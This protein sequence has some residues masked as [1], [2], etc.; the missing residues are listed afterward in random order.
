MTILWIVKWHSARNFLW[1]SSLL[2]F[3]LQ[4]RPLAVC[5]WHLTDPASATP[6]I[7]GFLPRASLLP[8][9]E[10]HCDPCKEMEVKR[11]SLSIDQNDKNQWLNSPLFCLWEWKFYTTFLTLSSKIEPQLF[12]MLDQLNNKPILSPPPRFEHFRDP[13]RHLGIMV[14]IRY[15]AVEGEFN[16]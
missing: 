13:H 16:I 7:S 8:A 1:L 9:W 12:K 14:S 3:L 6:S 15:H 10:A 11:S 4:I 5:G 2:T